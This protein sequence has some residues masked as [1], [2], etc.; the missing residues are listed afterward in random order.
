MPDINKFPKQF[1]KYSW[2]RKHRLYG[3]PPDTYPKFLWVRSLETRFHWLR[4]NHL[5]EKT[6]A[7]YLLREMFEWGGSRNG[8]TETCPI[9]G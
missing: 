7:I 2:A 5:A 3:Y 8:I 9:P 4:L 6:T 1:E